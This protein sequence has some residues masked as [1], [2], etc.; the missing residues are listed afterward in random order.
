MTTITATCVLASQHAEGFRKGA[1]PKR[2]DTLLL[3]YPRCIHSEFMTHRAFSRNSASSRA[4]PVKK[5][6]DDVIADPFVP[7]VWG[8]NQKG[9]QAGKELD[10]HRLWHA[11]QR[12]ESA[13]QDALKNA[14]YLMDS[15]AHKQI[16]NRLLEPWMHI[17]VVCTSTEW[18]NFFALRD[19]PDA[20]PH[21]RMLAQA[22]RKARDAATV[23]TLKRGEWHLPFVDGT[24]GFPDVTLD[25]RGE[26]WGACEDAKGEQYRALIVDMLK[27]SVARCASTS[28]KTVEGFDMTLE[29]AIALHDRLVSSRPMH[30]SPLEHQCMPDV[31]WDFTHMEPRWDKP[32]LHGNLVGWQQYRRILEA[33][34]DRE[35]S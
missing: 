27:L 34:E 15:G 17:T 10:G 4:I 24:G 12:W 25:E 28:Y 31:L 14:G 32:K 23:Q 22:I 2:V 7:L 16:V 11:K 13:L 33:P 20:E 21:M 8:E 6:I 35:P 5:L 19:H 3:R 30:A 18:D 26:H 9:M 29:R 1:E